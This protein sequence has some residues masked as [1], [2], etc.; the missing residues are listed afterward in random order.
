MYILVI[1]HDERN[2]VTG[3]AILSLAAGPNSC[4]KSWNKYFVNG[5]KFHTKAWSDGK[6][7]V[8]CGVHVKGV[9]EGGED[10]FFGIIQYIYELQYLG[11]SNKIPLFYCEWFDPTR[12]RGTRVYSQY[13]I[14]E[15]KMTRKYGLYDPFILAQKARQVY[16]VPYPETCKDLRGWFVAITTKPRGHVEVD[17]IENKVPYQADEMSNVLPITELEQ[18]QGLADLTIHYE[19]VVYPIT[20]QM[21]QD[22]ELQDE[23]DEDAEGLEVEDDE[24]EDNDNDE[25]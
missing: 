21:V 3:T 25:D 1:V 15:I 22:N 8:N 9:S 5:Y 4:A 20:K 19:H 10:D 2:R 17:G 7:T 11:L 6:K 13:N 18:L 14:V 12:N 23:E 16:Y 24:D